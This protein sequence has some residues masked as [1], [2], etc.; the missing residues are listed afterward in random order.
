MLEVIA[1]AGFVRRQCPTVAIIHDVLLSAAWFPP[2]RR[3][4]DAAAALRYP[5][6]VPFDS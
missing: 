2:H 3:G 5:T 1:A 4:S 6:V